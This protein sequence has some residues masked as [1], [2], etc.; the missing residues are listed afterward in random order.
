VSALRADAEAQVSNNAAQRKGLRALVVDDHP[1]VVNA[2]IASLTSLGT[3]DLI[4]HDPSLSQ[5]MA[6]LDA[7][8]GYDIV[9]LDLNLG[10]T[11]GPETMIQVRERYPDLPVVIF[12]ADESRES[13]SAAYEHGVHGYLP[14]S[15]SM[16]VI[17]NAIRTVLAGSI[18]IPPQMIRMLGFSVPETQTRE[19]AETAPSIKLSPRQEQ[20]F[21]YLLQ[22]MPN[23]VIANR[24]G[25]A[26]GTVKTHLN[27]IYRLLGVNSRAQVILR[28]REL[29]LI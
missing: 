22:G 12:S 1:I 16:P 26:E 15:F 9:I 24:L 19:A 5:A 10:D 14:K 21:H 23:K 17:V 27:T 28:A 3:F 4:D 25:M 6:R 18:Y 13:I 20:V 7:D 2:L 29:G 8:A 11:Q